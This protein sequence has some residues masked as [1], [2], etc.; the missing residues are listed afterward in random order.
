MGAVLGAFKT[1]FVVKPYQHHIDSDNLAEFGSELMKYVRDQDKIMISGYIRQNIMDTFNLYIPLSIIKY[2]ILYTSLIMERWETTDCNI[3][4][5][6]GSTAKSLK[7]DVNSIQYVFGS[8]LVTK[9]EHLWKIKIHSIKC[10]V[11]MGFI[12]NNK[13]INLRDIPSVKRYPTQLD[14]YLYGSNGLK[15]VKKDS[16][17]WNQY[18]MRR[19]HNFKT[20]TIIDL[21]F[22]LNDNGSTIWIKRNDQYMVNSRV[23]DIDT[24][25]QYRL[26]LILMHAKPKE[27]GTMIEILS[28]QYQ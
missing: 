25:I 13:V 8:R 9:G 4:I 11:Y 20:N 5:I 26:T 23:Y 14:G 2:C 15:I 16:S 28:Y 24:T 12:P 17:K 7:S 3:D 27:F 1:P 6:N 19:G 10:K 21:Y 18:P 22:Y